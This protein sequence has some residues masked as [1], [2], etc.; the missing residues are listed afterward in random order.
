LILQ[1]VTAAVAVVRV[2]FVAPGSI[3]ALSRRARGDCEL[4][5]ICS[6]FGQASGTDRRAA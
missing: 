6:A 2:E 3:N 1:I 5:H 4:A